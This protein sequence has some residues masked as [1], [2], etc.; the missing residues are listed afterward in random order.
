MA[1]NLSKNSFDQ[2]LLVEIVDLKQVET[3]K[4]KR[5]AALVNASTISSISKEIESC[6]DFKDIL[7]KLEFP[8]INLS[9]VLTIKKPTFVLIK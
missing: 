9:N 5:L 2:G 1:P 4:S 8:A 3:L 6:W 7:E